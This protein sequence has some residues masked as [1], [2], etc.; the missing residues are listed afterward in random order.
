MGR[1]TVHDIARAAG[2]SLATVDRVLNARPGV[3]QNTIIR[4]NQ[5]IDDIGY[6]RDVAAANLARSRSFSFA[7][8]LP[9][10]ATAFMDSLRTE[11]AAV[12]DHVRMDRI[13]LTT[14]E[15][16][17]E[18][19]SSVAGQIDRLIAEGTDGIAVMAVE[20]PQVRDAIRRA[21][22]KGIHVVTLV[23]DLP[24]SDRDHFVGI[25]NIAAGRTA[26]LLMGRFTGPR[27]GKVLVLAAT[28]LARD[29]SERR[30][31]FDRVM[32]AEFPNLTVLPTLECHDDPDI[33]ASAVPAALAAHPDILGIYSIGAGNRALIRVLKAH[34]HS[35]TIIA[36]ELSPHA[37][38]ALEDGTFDVVI[39]Q[40]T[41]H[42]ARSA[43]RVLRAFAEG[44]QIIAAQ[45]RIRLD[46]FIRENLP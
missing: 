11:L 34:P 7:F 25:N 1:P 32:Q 41:G 44:R 22:A 45:E 4:V 8:L 27:P 30:L 19:P 37:R 3:R 20:T 39:T 24:L 13:A 21:R 28:M 15:V 42:I 6:V 18:S 16:P 26:A 40:D 14:I 33:I 17:A 36:H 9:D 43:A 12:R 38:A 2:V 10:R 31:G 5:A 29:H 23:S 35:R 46:V